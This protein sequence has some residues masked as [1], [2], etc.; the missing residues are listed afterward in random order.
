MIQAYIFDMDGTLVDTE[1]LWVDAVATFI[2]KR[3]GPY[4]HADAQALVY[5]RSWHDIYADIQ[6]MLP[7]LNMSIDAV[8]EEMGPL[9]REIE[10]TQDVRIDSSIRLLR[11]LSGEAPVCIVSGSSRKMIAANIVTMNIA[12]C[13]RFYLGAEDYSP[14]KPDPSCFLMAARRLEVLPEACVVFEDSAAGVLGAKR[15]G[16]YAVGL[17]RRGA[18][19]QDLS[20]ADV[21]LADLADFDPAALPCPGA[22]RPIAS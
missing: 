3:L 6:G 20:V 9:Y 21:V 2:R 11:R 1:S 16:M 4:A 19:P 5:G 14:G 7:G 17:A 15:A 18:M 22:S 12:D 10:V 8:E 13:V